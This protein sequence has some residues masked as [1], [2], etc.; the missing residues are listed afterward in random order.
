[1]YLK[2]LVIN[3]SPRGQKGNTIKL[4]DAFVEGMRSAAECSVKTF[5]LRTMKISQ[6]V[7]CFSCWRETPG[8][9]VFKDDVE[10]ILDYL[11]AA[12][13]VIWSFPLYFFGMPSKLKSLFDR[14]LP[15]MTPI[16]SGNEDTMINGGHK[17]RFD[18]GKKRFMAIS[19]CG[20]YYTPAIYDGITGQLNMVYGEGGYERIFVGEG[21]LFNK[22]FLKKKIDA[23]LVHVH[24]AGREFAL[25]GITDETRGRVTE[26]IYPIKFYADIADRSWGVSEDDFK[27]RDE[28]TLARVNKL[29]KTF[30]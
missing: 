9:C 18:S 13:V 17:F 22:P 29:K 14:Q 25:G 28:E 6:C 30:E 2:V 7:G 5:D 10:M 11:L 19:T 1:M 16:M 27:P 8:A 15:L 24:Q 4:T 21:E 20:F 12:D 26:M 23:Y 3:A